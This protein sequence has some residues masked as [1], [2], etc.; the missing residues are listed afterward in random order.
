MW[1]LRSRHIVDGSVRREGE[2]L[3]MVVELVDSEDGRV[4]WSSSQVVDRTTLGAAQLVLVGRIAGTLQ[5]KVA[6]N[7]QR[8]ALTQPPR[9]LNAYVL[10]AHG[11][12]ML[13]RYSA[14]G[15]RESRRYFEQALAIDPEYAPAWAYLG[16]TNT[17]DIG[18]KLTGEWDEKRIG[19][20]LAQ[21]RQAIAL[22]PDLPVAYVALS[23][24]HSR[25][26]NLDA[27]LAAAQQACRLSPND[28]GC[29]YILG[30]AQLQLG[31]VEPALRNL[32]Q[33]MDRN[34]IPPAYLP[35]FHAT[36]LWASRRFEDALHVA[37]DCLSKAPDFWRCH[38]DRI[39][40][41]VEMGRLPEARAEAALLR[42][43]VPQLTAQG[44][45]STF[46]QGGIPLRERRIAAARS[47][48]MP[49]SAAASP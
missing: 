12:A 42:A 49:D 4:V 1:R 40:S 11:R 46:G 41:L 28:S 3:R 8:R 24:A 27:A 16:I 20:V 36:A 33:A 45:G 29:F 43:K 48:G 22:Q 38:Q 30:A 26:G 6:R 10:V 37:D 25:E 23:Q 44:F 14:Q 15:M 13:E 2:Q 31:Q 21:I 35:A 9:S 34:P 5:S 47:A 39:V 18:L 32:E 7:E 19:E 17:V